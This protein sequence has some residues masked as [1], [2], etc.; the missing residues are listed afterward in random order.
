MVKCRPESRSE[1]QRKVKDLDCKAKDRSKHMGNVVKDRKTTSDFIKSVL[2]GGT[3]ESAKEIKQAIR[4]AGEDVKKEF[5]RQRE[6]LKDLDRSM[7][8]A[9]KDLK[10]R[11]K[12]CE[13]DYNLIT[14]N[15]IG[16]KE[17]P[18]ARGE[19]NRAGIAA[20][21]EVDTMYT[22]RE[23]LMRTIRRHRKDIN[24]YEQEMKKQ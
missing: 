10:Q 20:Q 7:D 19:M 13:S 8:R 11:T 15:L 5:K 9:I 14:K 24:K 22:E 21:K 12:H 2:L 16:I 18:A 23:K 3:T 17:A 6:H 4:Q 1:I